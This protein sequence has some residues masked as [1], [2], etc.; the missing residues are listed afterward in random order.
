MVRKI[1]MF[2]ALVLATGA[3]VISLGCNGSVTDEPQT[4]TPAQP[5]SPEPKPAAPPAKDAEHGHKA[6]SH[7]G[8]IVEIGRDNYHAEA[9]FEKGGTLR[10]YTLGKDEA[11][12]Q[13]VE[14]QTLTAY[15]KASGAAE[16][17]PFT[18]RPT[19]Q[20]GDADGQTSQFVGTLPKEL[21][22]RRLDVTVPSL[23]IAGERFRLG[24]S[25]GAEEAHVGDMPKKVADE[26]E[27]TLY[28]TPAG[29]YTAADIDANGNVT[30]SQKFTGL[31][32]EHDLKPKPGDKICPITL[33]K[34]NPKFAWV[35]GGKSY[36]F[37]CPPCVDE[38]LTTAKEKPGEI[39]DPEEYRKK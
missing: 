24:F 11:R 21:W 10:L 18:L 28:L 22:G 8:I 37:C 1:S 39:L 7:G 16:A 12:V 33:T 38:F 19:P 29:K 20:P 15:A 35:I 3:M 27:R 9:V 13:E 34:A 30:A 25:S 14:S 32:A 2:A 4:A 36:Q 17:M 6:G 23:R 31:K 5:V 26:E